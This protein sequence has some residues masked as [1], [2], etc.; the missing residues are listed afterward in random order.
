MIDKITPRPDD[1]VREMLSSV[2]F[3]GKA[4]DTA[5]TGVVL[6]HRSSTRKRRNIS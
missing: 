4:D 5:S 1:G 2:G 3:G 6:P